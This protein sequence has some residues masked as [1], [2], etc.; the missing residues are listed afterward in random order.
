M[1]SY[2]EAQKRA[3]GFISGVKNL[4]MIW[5]VTLDHSHEF[6]SILHDTKSLDVLGIVTDESNLDLDVDID[7]DDMT[8]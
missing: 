1:K 7:E 6:C 2:T 3:L 5:E 4:E 8:L